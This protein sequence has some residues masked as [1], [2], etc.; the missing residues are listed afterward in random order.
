VNTEQVNSN[1]NTR[2]ASE[3]QIRPTKVI[4]GTSW[5]H[6]GFGEAGTGFL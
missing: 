2:D 1:E 6:T 5:K 3:R 4:D